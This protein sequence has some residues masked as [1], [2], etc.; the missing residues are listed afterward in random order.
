MGMFDSVSF[1]DR[2]IE[3]RC[4]HGHALRSFQ[5]KDFDEPSMNMYLVHD[6]RL[7]L[8]VS[9]GVWHSE[10]EEEKWRLEADEAIREHRFKLREI[11]GPLTVR[12]YGNCTGC[13]PILVRTGEPGLFGDIVTE[14][15]VFVDFRLTFRPEAPT[16]VERTS[17]N[18]DELKAEL[19]RRG[20][21]VLE[22]DEPLAIAHRE[23]KKARERLIPKAPRRR[24]HSS[25]W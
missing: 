5:T 20:V 10:G 1:L 3:L 15:A 24:G 12:A 23:M 9:S 4:P 18:R 16:R 22:D 7:Y 8:A 17:G 19:R 6:G 14:H 25:S 13:D 21:Y 11:R 2:V